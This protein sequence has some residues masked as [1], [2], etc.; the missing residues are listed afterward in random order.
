MGHQ[1]KASVQRD[2]EKH[3]TNCVSEVLGRKVTLEDIKR[4]IKE[5]YI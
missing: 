1:F 5:G 3:F 2:I 4:A